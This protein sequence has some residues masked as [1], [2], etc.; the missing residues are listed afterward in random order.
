MTTATKS[1]TK[2][3]TPIPA[4]VLAAEESE[5]CLKCADLPVP[6]DLT[7]EEFERRFRPIAKADGAL[8]YDRDNPADEALIDQAFA[9]RRLW[10]MCDGDYDTLYY[11]SG[12]HYVNR[13]GYLIT[14]VPVPEG[15]AF[16]VDVEVDAHSL[17]CPWCEREEEDVPHERYVAISDGAPCCDECPGLEGAE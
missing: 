5:L 16:F 9:E 2:C 1:C 14:E 3:N 4:P 12:A 8:W 7:E 17:C 10:T 15:E 6:T 11:W 13:I